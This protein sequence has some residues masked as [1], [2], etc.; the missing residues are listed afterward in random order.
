VASST[1]TNGG[2]PGGARA[3]KKDTRHD[4]A[5]AGAREGVGWTTPGGGGASSGSPGP[6]NR[7]VRP[8]A[9]RL[10]GQSSPPPCL[11]RTMPLALLSSA[12]PVLCLRSYEQV[13][14]GD[15]AV[16]PPGSLC[17]RAASSVQVRRRRNVGPTPDKEGES[18]PRPG[19]VS[20]SGGTTEGRGTS[21]PSP[22]GEGRARTAGEGDVTDA[23]QHMPSVLPPPPPQTRAPRASCVGLGMS[24][25]TAERARRASDTVPRRDRARVPGRRGEGCRRSTLSVFLREV[26]PGLKLRR[27]EPSAIKTIKA[28]INDSSAAVL[29]CSAGVDLGLFLAVSEPRGWAEGH[30]LGSPGLGLLG[31]LGLGGEEIG[32][33]QH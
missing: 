25:F 30:E 17:C 4:A 24:Y 20:G 27:V 15:G 14:P 26:P 29:S 16:R 6:R 7:A 10:A 28:H 23:P 2:S 9:P 33:L 11:R 1:K 22:A 32:S 8:L 18:D 3:K 5:A 13:P 21:A 12:C 19:G 31:L